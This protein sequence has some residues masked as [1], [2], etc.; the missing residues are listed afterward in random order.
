MTSVRAKGTNLVKIG[1]TA[2]NVEE[3]RR[4]LQ[5]GCPH[6]LVVEL[7]FEGTQEDERRAHEI[8]RNRRAVGEWFQLLENEVRSLR[9]GV[10]KMRDQDEQRAE[11]ADINVLRKRFVGAFGRGHNDDNQYSNASIELFCETVSA[12]AFDPMLNGESNLCLVCDRGV[13]WMGGDDDL[14][15]SELREDPRTTFGH[16]ETCPVPWLTRAAEAI[17]R[18]RE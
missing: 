1:F 10:E 8:H 7:T 2:G 14:W 18:G 15:T 11:H 17:R 13:S 3:R 5:T 4:A 16:R 6:E 12:S 9:Y